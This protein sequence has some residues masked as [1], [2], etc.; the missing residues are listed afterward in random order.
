[1]IELKKFNVHKIVETE[2]QAK[3]LVSLG[4]EILEDKEEEQKEN[5]NYI[6]M[7]MDQL[8]NICKEKGLEGYSN[9]NKDDLVVFMQ[10]NIKE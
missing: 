5:V 7:T 6:N 10:E 2:E 4:F 3:K 9:L 1:M 8:R